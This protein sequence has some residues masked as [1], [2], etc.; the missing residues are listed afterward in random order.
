M[1]LGPSGYAYLVDA[2]G[3]VVAGSERA[4]RLQDDGFRPAVAEA[5]LTGGAGHQVD[6]VYTQRIVTFAPLAD[7]PLR[8]VAVVYRH[9]FDAELQR[10]LWRGMLVFLASLVL[11][12]VQGFL[13]S[14][15]LTRPI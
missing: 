1:Q 11:T 2:S 4:R 8:V 9:D 5:V 13:F 6:R 15:R 10:M 14:R 7:R 3:T 12:L